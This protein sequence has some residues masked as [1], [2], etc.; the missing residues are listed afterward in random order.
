MVARAPTV[1]DVFVSS[2]SDMEEEREKLAEVIEDLN[3][4][5]RQFV[6]RLI[7]WKTH[8]VPGSGVAPQE[9]LNEELSPEKADIFIG[10]MWTRY[11][12]A[13]SNAGS[14]TEEEFDRALARHEQDPDGNRIMFYFK[15]APPSS[16]D[17]IDLDQLRRVRD[18][19]SRL[20]ESGLVWDFDTISAF[21]RDVRVHLSRLLQRSHDQDN[22][23]AVPD[24]VADL[25]PTAQ[26][27]D[28]L[29]Y[30]DYLV[31]VDENSEGLREIVRG[32]TDETKT[33]GHRL[34][35][36]TN[37]INTVAAR[38]KKGTR[39]PPVQ[40]KS[41]IDRAATDLTVYA[42]SVKTKL[43]LFDQRLLKSAI[44]VG[45]AA[46]LSTIDMKASGSRT[47]ETERQLTELNTGM[48][49]AIAGMSSF[50]Q[51]VLGLPSPIAEMNRAKRETAAI[52]QQILRTLRSA[53]NTIDEARQTLG[54]VS[55]QD[56]GE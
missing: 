37:E 10:L 35:Q 14:G 1:I 41:L 16:L 46:K 25:S 33:M 34:S 20:I 6:L 21:E 18:F 49:G 13:T 39:I 51:S 19:K 29:G 8:G 4:G 48:E 31:V 28:E 43:P 32:I 7:G 42:D 56:N 30:L 22:S 12:T 52:I 36:R 27:E 44:A 15:S 47:A 5:S 55:N 40:L 24:Q 38:L 23:S 11:G 9:L 3:R 45:Q 50:L 2:P 17:E 53:R 54:D 26:T